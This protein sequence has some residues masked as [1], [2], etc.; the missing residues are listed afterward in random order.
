VVTGVLSHRKRFADTLGGVPLEKATEAYV[1]LILP[2]KKNK[3]MPAP[4][5][6]MGGGS[7]DESA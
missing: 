1:S 2:M 3:L 4:N 5:G 7:Y 6:E